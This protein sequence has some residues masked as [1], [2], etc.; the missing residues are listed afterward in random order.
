MTMNLG[1]CRVIF[2]DFVYDELLTIQKMLSK[3]DR[4]PWSISKIINLLLKFYFADKNNPIYSK[5]YSFLR[6]YLIKKQVFLNQFISDILISS[7]SVS[8]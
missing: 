2:Q 1:Y 5:K 8:Y 7:T 6:K 4:K 3:I